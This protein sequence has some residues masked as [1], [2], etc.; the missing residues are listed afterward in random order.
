MNDTRPHAAAVGR[1]IRRNPADRPEL[2]GMA[3]GASGEGLQ[4]TSWSVGEGS[5]VFRLA[6]RSASPVAPSHQPPTSI[7]AP[8]VPQ[9]ALLGPGDGVSLLS[10]P[11]GSGR[12]PPA[13]RAA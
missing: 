4:P 1:S 7:L 3:S 9:A 11:F 8:D 5:I 6:W 10:V 12:S 2:D 13:E